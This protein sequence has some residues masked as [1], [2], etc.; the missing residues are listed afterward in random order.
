MFQ[1]DHIFQVVSLRLIINRI[2]FITQLFFPN[3][4]ESFQTSTRSLRKMLTQI[5]DT[6]FSLMDMHHIA[7]DC[8]A[9]VGCCATKQTISSSFQWNPLIKIFL[10]N[11]S[12]HRKNSDSIPEYLWRYAC[13]NIHI[14]TK[15]IY[16]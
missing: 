7:N 6:I 12:S 4:N 9:T 1:L 3:K 5:S 16:Q 2:A 14:W 8:F 10:F 13:I 15:S 11:F